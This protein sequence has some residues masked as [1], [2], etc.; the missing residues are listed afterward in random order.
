MDALTVLVVMAVFLNLGVATTTYMA[1]TSLRRRIKHLATSQQLTDLQNAVTQMVAINSQLNTA[2]QAAIT[3]LGDLFA[4][5][6]TLLSG[7]TIDP[8]AVEAV[9]Q[10]IAG[11]NAQLNTTV[12]AVNAA[13][14]AAPDPGPTP[15]TPGTG[16]A[17]T[18]SK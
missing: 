12:G 11:I 16:A 4:K 7:G 18:T 13:V 14:A 2:I 17:S 3:D 8:A 10:Q 15:G 1:V 9:A 5:L 6:Q